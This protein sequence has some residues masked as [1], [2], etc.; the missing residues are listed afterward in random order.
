MKHIKHDAE[1]AIA[2]AIILVIWFLFHEVVEGLT[3][4]EIDHRDFF[5]MVAVA[6]YFRTFRMVGK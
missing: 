6:A 3:E 4:I 1:A 5:G 2:L